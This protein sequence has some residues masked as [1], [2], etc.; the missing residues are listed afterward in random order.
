M[1]TNMECSAS[2]GKPGLF[3]TVREGHSE[4]VAPELDL[5]GKEEKAP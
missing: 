1:S 3:D 5:K 4:M 2:E